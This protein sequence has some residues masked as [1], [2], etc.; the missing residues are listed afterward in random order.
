MHSIWAIA[1]LLGQMNARTKYWI[2]EERVGSWTREP[3]SIVVVWKLMPLQLGGVGTHLG[4]STT[5][6][7]WQFGGIQRR[8]GVAVAWSENPGSY[9]RASVATR[10]VKVVNTVPIIHRCTAIQTGR[11]ARNLAIDPAVK[12]VEALTATLITI[13]IAPN[14]SD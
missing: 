8:H 7:A 11:W 3:R 5:D 2:D 4:V 1:A 13:C 9:R 12:T 6:M 10:R 14:F